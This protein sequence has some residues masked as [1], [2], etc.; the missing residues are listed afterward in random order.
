[1][2]RDAEDYTLYPLCP[3]HNYSRYEWKP[4]F[5]SLYDSPASSIPVI[6]APYTKTSD[7]SLVVVSGQPAEREKLTQG[8][9]DH[10]HDDLILTIFFIVHF[11]CCRL[12]LLLFLVSPPFHAI[13]AN[14]SARCQ[15]VALNKTKERM[16][17][18]HVHHEN[19][20]PDIKKIKKVTCTRFCPELL[21]DVAATP[22]SRSVRLRLLL[23]CRASCAG[24][25]AAGSGR[26]SCRTT[27]ARR[28]PR[29]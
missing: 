15:I 21:H 23:R 20:D 22:L 11:L 27:S 18:Y 28:T 2:T 25:S 14:F 1:M 13:T 6:C 3:S 7:G 5:P 8:E 9:N 19:E 4:R 29:A 10:N 16:R 17:P 12:L 24:G 26:S